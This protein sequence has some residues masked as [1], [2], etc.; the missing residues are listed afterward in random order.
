MNITCCPVDQ[1]TAAQLAAW[2]EFQLNDPELDSPF[3]RPE[4]ALAVVSAV[5]TGEVAVW[6]VDGEPAG[7]WPFQRTKW[8]E[9]KPIAYGA[10]D[11]DGVICRK[12]LRWNAEE[13]IRRCGLR[14]WDFNHVLASQQPLQAFHWKT[15]ASPFMDLSGGFDHYRA[16]VR[17]QTIAQVLRKGRK[18]ER[19]VGPLRLEAQTLDR[20]VFETLIRWKTE[21]YPGLAEATP[22]LEC[23]FAQQHELFSGMLTALYAGDQLAAVHLGMRSRHVLHCWFPA[24]NQS[25]VK[26]SPGLVMWT[27]LAKDA[28]KIGIQRIDLGTDKGSISQ[29]KSSLMSGAVEV[30]EGFVACQPMAWWSR[31]SSRRA[32]KWLET[33]SLRGPARLLRNKGR[34][35]L[36]NFSK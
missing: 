7:F 5:K 13:L 35:F 31:Q 28:A 20:S 15:V 16:S 9:A 29:Y 10:S 11:F 6:E 24:Y 17:T 2:S 3:F 32:R 25:L 18:L 19:E 33:S 27:E 8:N 21:Q 36:H 1:L 4:F 23:I 22:L 14:A 30:A 26:Y 34:E 12:N